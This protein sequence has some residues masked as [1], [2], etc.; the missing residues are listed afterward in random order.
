MRKTNT[1]WCGAFHV[2]VNVSKR[3]HSLCFHLLVY[4]AMS[5]R[6]F[7][8]KGEDCEITSCKWEDKN[9]DNYVSLKQ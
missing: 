8:Y 9:K 1:E 6:S 5:N 7:Y 3:Y 2:Q 4:V